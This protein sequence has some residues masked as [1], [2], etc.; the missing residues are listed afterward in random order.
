MPGINN[1]L[2]YAVSMGASDL[3]ISCGSVPLM[4]VHGELRPL[5]WNALD[6]RE[7]LQLIAEILTP[8]QQK[9][10]SKQLDLDFC[11]EAPNIGSFRANILKQRNGVDAVFRIIPTEIRPLE[12]LG[13]PRIVKDLTH[14]HHGLVLV[15]GS[16]GNGKST[17]L[18]AMI[19]YI[20]SRR[21]LHIITVEDPI[22]FVHPPKQAN[23]SQREVKSHT[24]SFSTALRASLREDPDVILIGELRD[25]E[26]ISMAITAAE[27][28]HLVFG[29]L[30]TRT[31]AKTIDRII[32]VFPA[33]QQNQIRTQLSETLRGVVSQQLIPRAD[34][35]GRVV[36]YEILI[37]SP[38]VANLIRE[39]KTFQIPSLMQIGAK[40][41]M[42]LMDQCL[43][44]LLIERLITEE[45]AMYRTENKRLLAA[46]Q[47][48]AAGGVK[49]G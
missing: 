13:M 28:G 6:A 34:G 2:Q 16:A 47:K 33:N 7:T 19:D 39:G 41:G 35:K 43:S 21:K 31:A 22:E 36:A 20:N 27:T 45:E 11:Y 23:I 48:H 26:T 4:R 32:D 3:H 30:H 24:E 46:S 12:D 1:F 5:K 29:T 44:R 37:G 8:E 38:A 15:T 42:C 25:L 18:A 10:F 9:T 17:T 40:D 14:H 49:N